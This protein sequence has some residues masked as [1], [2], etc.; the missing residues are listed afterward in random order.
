MDVVCTAGP[1]DRPFEE[2]HAHIDIAIVVA[3]TFQYRRDAGCELMTPG[4]ILLGNAGERFECGHEHG[5]GDRCLSFQF[6]PEYFERLAADV[7]GRRVRPLFGALRLP[8]LREFS[9]LV[10][11]ACAR[12]SGA[13]DSAWEELSVQIGAKAFGIAARVPH[14]GRTAPLPSSLARMTRVVRKIENETDEVLSLG[15]L[16][17]EAG[18][19]PY[20]FLRSFQELTGLTPHQFVRRARLRKAA[21]RLAA[22]KEKVLDVA[23][24]SGFGDV[25]SFNRAFRTEFGQNPSAYR[26]SAGLVHGYQLISQ[27]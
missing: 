11:R 18:L 9:A 2:R 20:H 7:G 25:S 3:G 27:L 21:V 15:S 22:G 19:S 26:A 16:A 1:N 13:S 8:P 17:R 24:D 12:L 6:S 4:S 14:R 23:L 10:A 5:T